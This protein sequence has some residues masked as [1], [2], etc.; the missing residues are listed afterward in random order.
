MVELSG[1]SEVAEIAG[2]SRQ[3]VVNWRARFSDFPAPTAELAS[4]PVWVREDIEK[5]LT[6]REGDSEKVITGVTGSGKLETREVALS[7]FDRL[8]IANAIEAEITKADGFSVKVTTDDN[9]SHLVDFS[10]SGSTLTI[11]LKSKLSLRHTTARVEIGMPALRGIKVS[12]ATRAEVSGFQ[13]AEPL[14]MS[15]SGGSSL[16]VKDVKAGETHIFTA[17]ASHVSGRLDIADGRLEASGAS[18][19]EIGGQGGNI[20]LELSGASSAKLSELALAGA[21]IRLTGASKAAVNLNGKLD[22]DLSGASQLLY[23]GE[24]SLGKLQVAGASSLKLG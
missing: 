22:A 12:G 2:V 15:A 7:D 14:D 1:L 20:R 24:V 9:V 13:S 3:A 19:I 11:K 5:W 8:A 23:S 10:K 17:G 21:D 18:R 4:G 6:N 16:R